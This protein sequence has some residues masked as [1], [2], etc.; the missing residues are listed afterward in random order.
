MAERKQIMVLDSE[1]LMTAGVVSLLD[2]RPEIDV[3]R[4]TAVS[5]PFPD[6]QGSL[7]PAVIILDEELLA[8]NLLAL[9]KLADCHPALRLIVINV[10]DNSVHVFDKQTVY[11]RKAS[12]L[13]ELL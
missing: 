6:Q 3:I 4:T 11:V 12:D 1:K 7:Q 9:I 8:A 2:A 13:V 5:L 10:C